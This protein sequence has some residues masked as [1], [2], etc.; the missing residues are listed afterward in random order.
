MEAIILAGGFGS[1]LKSVVPNIPKPMALINDKPFLGY[2]FEYLL[3]NNVCK[4]ILSVG[5]KYE[6]IIE[7]FGTRYKDITIAYSI[8]DEPLGT[9]GGIKKALE[10]VHSDNV[11]ILNGDTFFD[12]SLDCLQRKHIDNDADLTLS[13][14]PMKAYDRY[15][16]V[17]VEMDR[18]I[19]FEEKQFKNSG[20]INGGIYIAKSTL[21]DKIDLPTKFSFELDF[22]E[23]YVESLKIYTYSADRY[24][25][26]IGI[27]EDYEK[28]RREL[29]L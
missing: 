13:L 29:P 6:S 10:L 3:R 23:N 17:I 2:L 14:K 5:Y 26:D 15:G 12:I 16:T 1:R 27:P 7:Y 18:V 4:V 28:A 11:F 20:N 25:I 9:G 19:S 8:E 22:M 24:F 21:F